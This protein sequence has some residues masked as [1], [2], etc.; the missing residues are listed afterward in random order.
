VTEPTRIDAARRRAAGAKEL[1]VATAAAGFIAVLLLARAGHPGHAAT[2]SSS[3][4]NS[5]S[6]GQSQS[7]SSDDDSFSFGSGSA[8]PST[9]SGG[10]QA[11]TSVS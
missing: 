6:T 7:E 9:G 3:R 11:Q 4:S 2:S 1:A 10:T 8:V 5:Q